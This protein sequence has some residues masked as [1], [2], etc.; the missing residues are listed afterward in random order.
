MSLAFQVS[1]DY[2][3]PLPSGVTQV[4]PLMV[5]N[6]LNALLVDNGWEPIEFAGTPA[7]EILNPA[8]P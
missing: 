1:L 5:A 6:T 2:T 4:T 8:G 7:E 3:G